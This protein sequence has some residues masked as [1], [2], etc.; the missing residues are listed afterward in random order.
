MCVNRPA[1]VTHWEAALRPVSFFTFRL[2]SARIAPKEGCGVFDDP[3]KSL[4]RI[5]NELLDEE[6]EDIL[7]GD[8]DEDDEEDA[9]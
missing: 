2:K 3:R 4:R 7:Y 1:F 9:Q 6:L 8:D 5:E